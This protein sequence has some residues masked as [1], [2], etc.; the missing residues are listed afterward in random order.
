MC[1]CS[2]TSYL[3]YCSEQ[4]SEMFWRLPVKSDG[5]ISKQ[6]VFPCTDAEDSGLLYPL[7]LRGKK[8]VH[9]YTTL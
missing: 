9:L 3:H 4:Y 8:A 5:Q 2:L 1:F 7:L 6:N